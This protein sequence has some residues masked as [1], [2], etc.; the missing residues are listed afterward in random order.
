MNKALTSHP[1]PA[2]FYSLPLALAGGALVTLSTRFGAGIGGDATTY[3][4]SA[5]NLLE[6]RGLGLVGPQG[7]FS[8]LALFPPGF[9]LTLSALGLAVV[10]A[11]GFRGRK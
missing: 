3:I 6:G 11:A 5:K 1:V 7:E 10:V 2:R 4:F 8:F 9:P